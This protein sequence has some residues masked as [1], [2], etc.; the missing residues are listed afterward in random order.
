MFRDDGPK[1]PVVIGDGQRQEG[2]EGSGIEVG[3]EYGGVVGS[4]AS[5]GTVPI[6]RDVEQKLGGV[7]RSGDVDGG[8]IDRGAQLHVLELVAGGEQLS[9]GE[10]VIEALHGDTDEGGGFVAARR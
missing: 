1:V 3:Q 2:V 7:G 6:G 9:L 10:V 4:K 8:V 5:G